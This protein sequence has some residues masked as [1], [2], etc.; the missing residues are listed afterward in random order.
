MELELDYGLLRNGTG[1]EVYEHLRQALR[2]ADATPIFQ[3]LL[4]S[5]ETDAIPGR[6]TTIWI[7]G[8]ADVPTLIN[9]IRYRH[10]KTVRHAAIRRFGLKLRSRDF[11]QVWEDAGGITGL[12]QLMTVLS[13]R[14]VAHLCSVLGRTATAPSAV[15]ERQN[16][17]DNLLKTLASNFFPGSHSKN[18]ETRPLLER[19][20]RILPACSEELVEAWLSNSNLP[21]PNNVKLCQAHPILLQRRCLGQAATSDKDFDFGIYRRLYQ[22]LPM[23]PVSKPVPTRMEFCMELLKCLAQNTK[24]MLGCLPLWNDLVRPLLRRLERR[25]QT[26]AITS[27][28]HIFL[29]CLEARKGYNHWNSFDEDSLFGYVLRCWKLDPNSSSH[30]LIQT[31]KLMP[32]SGQQLYKLADSLNQVPTAHRLELLKME[33]LHLPGLGIN[34]TDRHSLAKFSQLWPSGIFTRLRSGDGVWLLD[35]LK[36]ADPKGTFIDCHRCGRSIL[37]I[38]GQKQTTMHE[39]MLRKK[40]TPAEAFAQARKMV[41]ESKRKAMSSREQVERAV[42]ANTTLAYS[43]ATGSL[44]VLED[45]VKWLR[46]YNRD[47]TSLSTIYSATVLESTE[48]I[49]LL[50]GLETITEAAEDLDNVKQRV[51]HANRV[52]MLLLE[53]ACL[54]L[55]EPS[56]MAHNWRSV[57]NLFGRVIAARADSAAQ[58]QLVVGCT[59]AQLYDAVFTDTVEMLLEAERIGLAEE[60]TNLDYNNPAGPLQYRHTRHFGQ[61]SYLRLC[62]NRVI[63]RF[64]DEL[65]R[66]R[67]VLWEEQR[68]RD[69]PA[70][71]VL[72][73]SWPRG[74]PFQSLFAFDHAWLGLMTEDHCRLPRSDVM[75]FLYSKAKSAVFVDPNEALSHTPTDEETQTAIGGFVDDYTLALRFY[76]YSNPDAACQTHRGRFEEAQKSR[77][78]RAWRHAVDQLARAE[79]SFHENLVFWRGIFDEA[80]VKIPWFENELPVRREP[81]LPPA[82][83]FGAPVEWNPDPDYH[84]TKSRDLHETGLDCL[85][86]AG[87]IRVWD[88]QSTFERASST[89]PDSLHNSIWWIYNQGKTSEPRVREALV[90]AALLLVNGES[91]PTFQLLA[92]SSAPPTGA[93]FPTLFLDDEFLDR[94]D[95]RYDLN[96]RFFVLRR[97]KNDVPASLL[98]KLCEAMLQQVDETA[99]KKPAILRNFCSCLKLMMKGDKPQASLNLI[100][101]IIICRPDESSWHRQI[102]TTS[103]LRTLPAE[104]AKEFFISIASE[105]VEALEQQAQ[106]KLQSVGERSMQPAVKITTIKLIAQLLIGA[107]FIDEGTVV[108]ALMGIFVKSSHVDARAAIVESLTAIMR[109]SKLE[110]TVEKVVQALEIYAVPVAAAVNE[111]HAMSEDQWR[112]TEAEGNLPE[113]AEGSNAW[114]IADALIRAV[115]DADE[116]HQDAL[117]RRVWLPLIDQSARNNRRWME[118]FLRLNGFK[119]PGSGLPAVPVRPSI[120]VDVVTQYIDRVPLHLLKTWHEAVMCNLSPDWD[121][122]TVN[123]TV[124]Q[125]VDL[126]GSNAGEHWQ[127]LWDRNRVDSFDYWGQPFLSL[128]RLTWETKVPNGIDYQ[129]VVNASVTQI[130]AVIQRADD[131]LHEQKEILNFLEPPFHSKQ[132]LWEHWRSGRRQLVETFISKIDSMRTQAWQRDPRRIPAV[133]PD[134]YPMKL[135]LLS[136][137]P[138]DTDA[139]FAAKEMDVFA[140]ELVAEVEKLANNGRAY[141]RHFEEL[142]IA[143]TRVSAQDRC[144]LAA[145]I[146]RLDGAVFP[147]GRVGLLRV[148]LADSLLRTG[149]RGEELH[150]KMAR[151]MLEQWRRCEDED[152]RMTAIKTLTDMKNDH[153]QEKWWNVTQ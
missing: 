19:Y 107:D 56:F 30:L 111:R 96:T 70:V 25:K 76:V 113:I 148:E 117:L 81:S 46:R 141:H 21:V 139:S 144:Y 123:E 15:A 41:E 112:Q 146:G 88:A 137:P 103:F 12:V 28:L 77:I 89:S 63:C 84:P 6:V 3:Q 147:L 26:D 68:R 109:S 23:T 67:N 4:R 9:A 98:T 27:I 32:G 22:R 136:Y 58:L 82:G 145:K 43:I 119:W 5:V 83:S 29:R 66:R 20:A 42:S 75:P 133:L 99:T 37:T 73:Q 16:C 44:D 34:L 132:R 39:I 125:S 80:G 129:S 79:L 49:E 45:V 35:M 104:T 33:L 143:S 31:L 95:H 36:L 127:S 59:D 135:W 13:V 140:N 72:P 8:I 131:S 64:V 85:L 120:L 108:E 65:A 60:H 47:P 94:E 40:H 93:R 14:G 38:D 71:A 138:T 62:S 7:H 74:L 130:T 69:R 150:A 106:R 121:L 17:M 48:M 57:L 87:S 100:R 122:Y 118:L 102:L 53:T 18:P 101:Y 86:H 114:P 134:T 128:L 2:S 55:R 110:G 116:E 97:F 126:R 124:A 90:A 152:V 153:G 10:S 91:C 105:T 149:Q 24:V 51:K 78:E 54:C 151:D 50:A 1:G 61:S 142:K 92:A 115:E 11:H 52:I